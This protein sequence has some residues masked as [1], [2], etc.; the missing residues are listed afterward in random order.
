MESELFQILIDF[1]GTGSG[2]LLLGAVFG[3]AIKSF[4]SQHAAVRTEVNKAKAIELLG[5]QKLVSSQFVATE[6]YM[7]SFKTWA[8]EYQAE[9]LN[10]IKRQFVNSPYPDFSNELRLAVQSLM[11]PFSL[12]FRLYNALFQND[13]LHDDESYS[14]FGTLEDQYEKN[15]RLI[16]DDLTIV[17]NGLE[18]RLGLSE[19]RGIAAI[20]LNVRL[21]WDWLMA[22]FVT[23]AFVRFPRWT[24]KTLGTMK[25][26]MFDQGYLD[27]MLIQEEAERLQ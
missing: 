4:F 14:D 24:I 10:D 23:N 25:R 27:M 21:F 16:M 18:R 6:L 8:A 15:L 2:R 9:D 11:V 20:P 13:H 5:L 1:L 26:G 17:R 22:D 7:S 3:Y 12:R 19:L